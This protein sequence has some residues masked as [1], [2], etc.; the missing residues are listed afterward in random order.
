MKLKHITLFVILF[1]I[2]SCTQASKTEL[3][4]EAKWELTSLKNGETEIPVPSGKKAWMQFF[5]DGKHKTYIGGNSDEGTW[6]LTKNED[7]LLV[8]SEKEKI[9]AHI[10]LLTSEKL[11]LSYQMDG[12]KFTMTLKKEE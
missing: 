2:I 10:D 4:C 5:K 7:S 6:S 3:L 8:A 1:V 12:S 11:H 9:S